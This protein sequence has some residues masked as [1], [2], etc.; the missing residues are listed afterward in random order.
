MIWVLTY[1]SGLKIYIII[2]NKKVLLLLLFKGIIFYGDRLH[3][4]QTVYQFES[5]KMIFRH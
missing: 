3:C 1:V 2:W 5:E 4:Y